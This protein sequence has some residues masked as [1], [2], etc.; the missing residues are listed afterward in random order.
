MLSCIIADN[1]PPMLFRI[2]EQKFLHSAG[3]YRKN[4]MILTGIALKKRLFRR[5]FFG[6]VLASN[7]FYT[8]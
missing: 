7:S 6:Q 1:R 5:F 3:G 8:Q 2:I 4:S